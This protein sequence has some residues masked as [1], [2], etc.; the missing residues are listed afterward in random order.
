MNGKTEG[1]NNCKCPVC[2]KEFHLKPFHLKRSKV[3]YCSQK[4][5]Y[6]AKK[7]YMAGEK[8]HQYGL[9]GKDNAS[10]KSDVRTS[11]YGYIQVRAPEHPFCDKEGWMFEHRLVAEEHL[12]DVVNSVVINGKA[13]LRPDY[14]VHHKNF[15]RKDNR[16]EN[17]MVLTHKEHKAL[18]FKL[19]PNERDEIGRFVKD[20]PD[21]IKVKKV[22]ETAVIPTK[23]SDGAAGFDLYADID[24]AVMIRPHETV[25]IPS[26]IAFEIPK[27][28]FG[29]IYARSGLSTKFGLRPSTCV[30]VIDSDYRGAV[31]LPIHNDT[32]DPK[33]VCPHERV[34]QIVFQKHL[35]ADFELVGELEDTD[36]G[37][38]GFGSTGR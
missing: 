30:S 32:N 1:W 23:G 14:Q 16:P 35:E 24:E 36:R 18:H 12:L 22:S 13:Y 10:W 31:G 20:E 5:H 2:G 38:G 15:D 19:N 37:I 28:Y 21:K 29:A 34:A 4:C 8:N 25:V 27:G 26:N 17:L 9:R 7:E 6:V 3:H 11:K 33:V